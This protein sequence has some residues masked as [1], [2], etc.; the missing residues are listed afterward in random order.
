MAAEEGSGYRKPGPYEQKTNLTPLP[1]SWAYG[2]ICGHRLGGGLKNHISS[3][4]GRAHGA[5][6]AIADSG[7][8]RGARVNV[9]HRD[10]RH[11][12]VRTAT[13]HLHRSVRLE[14]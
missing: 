13:L 9:R 2:S 8:G 5:A 10:S 7:P 1:C 12:S 6:D 4:S 11:G 3:R 14:T